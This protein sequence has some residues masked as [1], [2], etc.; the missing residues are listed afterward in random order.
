MLHRGKGHQTEVLYAEEGQFNPKAA[1]S[2]R[3]QV[4][5]TRIRCNRAQASRLTVSK[6]HWANKGA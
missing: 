3:K 1:R 2:E 5:L 6:P 4:R